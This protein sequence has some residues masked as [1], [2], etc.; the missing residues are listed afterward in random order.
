MSDAVPAVERG[1]V[2]SG[3]RLPLIDSLRA[4]AALLIFAYHALFVTGNLNPG[5]YGWYLN[6]GVPLFYAISGLLL[7]RPFAAAVIEGRPQPSVLAY[8]RHRV[9]RIVPAYWVALPV[10][11]VVLE[12]TSEVFTP[13]GIPTY[14]GFLQIYSLDTFVGGIGQAWT[15]CV[16]V[17]FYAFLPLWGL[18]CRWVCAGAAG[19]ARRAHRLLI[20]VG[21]LAAGSLAW[22]VAAV[23]AVG[24]NV[25]AALI[26][27]TVLPAALDQFAVGMVVAVA[28]AARNAGAG[29][30]PLLRMA[31]ARPMGLVV[32]AGVAY[33]LTGEAHGIGL[34]SDSPTLG[35]GGL[36]ITEHELK[37]VFAAALLLAAVGADPR[38]GLVG[39]ALAW[40]PLSRTG[41][42]SY[43]VYL[44]HLAI[45]VG[46]AGVASMGQ[47]TH[48]I[49]GSDGLVPGWAGVG[50]AFLITIAV[51]AASWRLLERRCID[52]SHRVQR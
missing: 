11:A 12:R 23:I 28:V 13:A 1:V 32:A 17:T 29:E 30:G 50:I 10:V 39:K 51:S 3:A 9:F 14:F 25:S 2:A 27:L 7:F 49:G 35:W 15:L 47:Q 48:W 45:L 4:I 37:A 34:V 16:E 20:L 31:A 36:A 19:G 21:G 52:A 33:W 8:A 44:W 42:I 43:G 18:L 46:F 38:R 40:Q 5:N 22:K 41:E 26:P 6:A 24:D